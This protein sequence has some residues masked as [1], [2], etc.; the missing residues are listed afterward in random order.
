MGGPFFYFAKTEKANTDF[1]E[2]TGI[3]RKGPA[4][5]FYKTLFPSVFSV[6]SVYFGNPPSEFSRTVPSSLPFDSHHSPED[7]FSPPSFP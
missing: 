3:H 2:R 7:F 5:Y 6:D 4:K 1:T